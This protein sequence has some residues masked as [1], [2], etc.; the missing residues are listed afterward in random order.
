MR[1][2]LVGTLNK[3]EAQMV[4]HYQGGRKI[5]VGDRV[6]YDGESSVVERLVDT[7]SAREVWGVDGL[8]LL[9][10][11]DKF[12]RVFVSPEEVEFVAPGGN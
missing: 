11:N 6:D 4:L 9:L 10:T 1:A 12:G 3:L 7:E 8:G 2:S 5:S